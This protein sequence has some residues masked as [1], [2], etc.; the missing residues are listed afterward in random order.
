MSAHLSQR[1]LDRLVGVHPSLSR[2]VK[3]AAEISTVDFGVLEGVR[4]QARQAELYAKGRTT[5]GPKVT[6]TMKSKHIP[7]GDGYG[8]AVD[9][10]PVKDGQIDW[11][12]SAGFAAINAAMMQ[13]AREQGTALRWGKDW[14][15]DGVPGE[16]GETDSPHWELV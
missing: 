9:L 16:K 11:S 3:R 6:W 10:A 14:D 12:D 5:P 2:I 13:A 1:S 8:R 7:A 15:G 4:T